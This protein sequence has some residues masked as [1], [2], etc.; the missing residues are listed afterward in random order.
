MTSTIFQFNQFLQRIAILVTV[1]PY[2]RSHDDKWPLYNFT[3][4]YADILQI[5]LKY[6]MSHDMLN[7]ISSQQCA[8]INSE[9][10][11]SKKSGKTTSNCQPY[12][13]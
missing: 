4:V 7:Q 11:Y 9:I 13:Y 8:N 12:T 1:C 3:K 5:R 2:G 10:N 6:C